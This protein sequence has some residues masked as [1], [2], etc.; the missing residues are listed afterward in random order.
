VSKDV[1]LERASWQSVLLY[2]VRDLLGILF[3]T[4][5][6]WSRKVLWRNE[7]YQLEKGGRMRRVH[8]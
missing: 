3:W 6:Y 4:A 7:I 8:R 2:P 1:L 5:S